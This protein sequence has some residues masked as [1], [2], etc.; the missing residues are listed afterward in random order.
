MAETMFGK[1]IPVVVIEDKH[2]WATLS[3]ARRARIT[4]N[5]QLLVQD[6]CVKLQD[7]PNAA[8]VTITANDEKMLRGEDC[9]AATQLAMKIIVAFAA[10]QGAKSL[11]SVS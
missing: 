2:I 8:A 6:A 3:H 10:I 1:S 11:I 5:G 4:S 9:S 7:P